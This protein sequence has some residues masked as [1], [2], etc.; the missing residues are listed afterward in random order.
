MKN[1][2]LLILLFL[3]TTS[4]NA[5]IDTPLSEE[6]QL[7][8]Q[9]FQ[10]KDY[11]KAV[12]YYEKLFEKNPVNYYYQP[13]LTCLIELKEYEKAEKFLT[14]LIKRNK[15]NARYIVDLGYVHASAGETTKATQLYEKAI[16]DVI[17]TEENIITLADAFLSRQEY[18][19]AIK[20]YLKGK[21]ELK[22]MYLFNF[23][24]A[25]VYEK[26]NNFPAML[27]EYI[28][29]IKNDENNLKRVKDI[30]QVQIFS[31]DVGNQKKEY[32]KTFLIKEIQKNPN[33]TFYYDLLIWLFIQMREFES[34]FLHSKALDK[35]L[36]EDGTRLVNL[37]KL[38]ASNLAYDVAIK[39]FQYV[40]DK[41]PN[42]VY[43]IES[44]I[45]LVDVMNQ[46]IINNV[47]TQHDL[48]ELEK[49]YKS[50]L[51]ELGKNAKT[52]KLIKGLAHLQAFYLNKT[53][54]AITLLE[55]AIKLPGLTPEFQAECKLE[56]ADILVFIEEVWDA[57]LLYSQV[58]KA[59]KYDVLGQEAKFRN[60]RLSYYIGEFQ[61]AKAQLDVLKAA[62][63]KLTANDAMQ[64][65][66][67][68]SDNTLMDTTPTALLIFARADLYIYQHKYDSA[69]ILFDSIKTNFPSHS[70]NDE[71]LFKK[72][73]IMIAQRNY[74]LAVAYL[75]TLLYDYPYDILAD[76]ALFKM[77]KIYETKLDNPQKAMECYKNLLTQ[78]PGSLYV[79]EA[80]K[81]YRVLR[82]DEVN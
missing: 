46:K 8:A 5:Q 15:D 43:Y 66:L 65:S 13:Y 51:E 18:D 75:D 61:W 29:A 35:R 82:G 79:V 26:Q 14:K 70:L 38:C 58:E 34:A 69:L 55:E 77:A 36:N 3:F 21:K 32:L 1:F 50:N 71:I 54:E 2:Y 42:N 48:I 27:Q 25:E 37:A 19:Y 67:L 12:V 6:E 73:K 57:K 59:F 68:I 76:D 47:Y 64:L 49:I 7:A 23:E 39:S 33:Q 56:L 80:R 78:Y 63:S 20:T 45:G 24:L 28:E 62:T 9:Y 10:D 52:A 22:G 31:D 60:A 74:P 81:R 4:V 41:G 72:A 53:E 17:P 40:I 16:K 30:L 44:K 11:E